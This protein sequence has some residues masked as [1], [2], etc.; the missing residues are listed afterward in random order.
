VSSGG[1]LAA[2]LEVLTPHVAPGDALSYRIVNTGSVGLICGLAYSL[3]R[4]SD[5][6]WVLMNPDMPFR[7]IGFRVRPGE[8]RKLQAVIPGDAPAGR[9]RITT[10]VNSDHADGPLLLSADLRVHPS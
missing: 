6:G 3:E 8:S 10:R 9:Y 1:R 4:E 2:T 5:A 7:A